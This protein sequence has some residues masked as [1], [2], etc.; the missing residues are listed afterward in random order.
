MRKEEKDLD[1]WELVIDSVMDSVKLIPF[2]FLTYL[3]ME[4]LEHRTG[5][6]AQTDCEDG[7]G[8]AEEN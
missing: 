6:G 7:T 3:I 5:E 8:C 4:Y 1:I 2:L